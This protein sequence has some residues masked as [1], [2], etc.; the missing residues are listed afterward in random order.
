MSEPEEREGVTSASSA[1]HACYHESWRAPAHLYALERRVV[2]AVIGGGGTQVGQADLTNAAIRGDY[3]QCVVQVDI[4][5]TEAMRVHPAAGSRHLESD[6]SRLE[7]REPL[8][9]R[10]GERVTRHAVE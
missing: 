7:Y 5:V 9:L 3:T 2:R 1:S 4:P 8:M 10:F 6:G